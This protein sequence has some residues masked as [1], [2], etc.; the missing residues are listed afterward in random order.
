MTKDQFIR[1]VKAEGVPIQPH[2]TSELYMDPIFQKQLGYG[3]SNC[4]F[5]CPL[6]RGRL[7]YRENLCPTAKRIGE[8]SFRLLVH[9]TIEREDLD[10]VI[11]A[12]NKVYNAY[13]KI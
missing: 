5:R 9:P 11:T 13:K 2:T 1:A 8:E 3:R 7:N 10:D 12:I 6:Y 4:P